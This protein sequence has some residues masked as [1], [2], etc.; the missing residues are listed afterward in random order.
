[1]VFSTFR[2]YTNP[3]NFTLKL[4]LT[5]IQSYLWLISMPR[6]ADCSA[7]AVTGACKMFKMSRCCT[8]ASELIYCEM[9]S[10]TW[11]IIFHRNALHSKWNQQIS[12]CLHHGYHIKISRVSGASREWTAGDS[13]S[14][15]E[16][17]FIQQ[18]KNNLF[19]IHIYIYPFK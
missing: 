17:I 2:K 18:A 7:E 1:M 10:P 14:N 8:N 3:P 5:P 19:S 6:A 11:L 16:H 12:A 13:R 15:K 9:L 4:Q